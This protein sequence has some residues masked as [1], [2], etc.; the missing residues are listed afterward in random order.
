MYSLDPQ[1][2]EEDLSPRPNHKQ[3]GLDEDILGAFYERSGRP[4]LGATG[5]VP[6]GSALN[7]PQSLNG[8]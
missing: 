8:E 1:H 2:T 5:L 4:V 6:D 3:S 7:P